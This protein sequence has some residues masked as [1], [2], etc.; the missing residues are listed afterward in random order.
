M[1]TILIVDGRY[2]RREPMT[3]MLWHRGHRVLEADSRKEALEIARVEKLDLLLTDERLP[4]TEAR[5]LAQE[6]GVERV[7]AQPEEPAALIG[8][9]DAAL[10]GQP[11][12]AGQV[13]ATAEGTAPDAFASRVRHRIAELESLTLQLGERVEQYEAQLDVARAALAQEVSKRIWAE[14]ELTQANL[15]LLD[16]AVRDSL[17]GLHNR[18]YLGES[19]ARE[20]SRARR[21]GQSVG[22]MM[23]DIDHFKRCNDTYGHAAGDAVLRAVAQ[24]AL[25]LTRGEDIFCRYGG[26]EFVLVLVNTSERAVAERA[27]ALRAG[28]KA[29]QIMHDGQRIGPITLSIGIAMIPGHAEDGQAALAAADAALYRAKNEGRDRVVTASGLG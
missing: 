28:V 16:W 21:S 7:V 22:V 9:V 20:E 14:K 3:A 15:L 24:Y 6:C 27:E 10:S 11:E 26:E 2:E 18:R 12:P 5:A 19:L 29:L 17:T 4:E 25:S 1:A 8:A 13:S 23:I